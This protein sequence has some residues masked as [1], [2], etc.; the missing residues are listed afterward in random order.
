MPTDTNVPAYG[1]QPTSWSSPLTS[2]NWPDAYGA[3]PTGTNVHAYGAQPKSSTKSRNRSQNTG[4]LSRLFGPRTPPAQSYVGYGSSGASLAPVASGI[5]GNP[6]M[7][8][9]PQPT[10][11]VIMPR[12]THRHKSRRRRSR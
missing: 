1:V 8:M 9:Y 11:T 2:R 6:Y 12:S 5:Q 7:Q 10:T 3:M 4:F